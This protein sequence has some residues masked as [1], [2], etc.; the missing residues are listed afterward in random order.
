MSKPRLCIGYG[1]FEGK[2]TNV[3]GSRWS[4][5]WCP[6]CDKLRLDHISSQ[7]AEINLQIAKA[8][9]VAVE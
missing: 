4:P 3:A 6:R 2:C 5:Y 8:K 9:G 7:L 1:E